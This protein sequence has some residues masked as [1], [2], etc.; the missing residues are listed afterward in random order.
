MNK[1]INT[2][3]TLNDLAFGASPTGLNKFNELI[4]GLEIMEK[5]CDPLITNGRVN[6]YW[7]QSLLE[8]LSDNYLSTGGQGNSS[9][10]MFWGSKRIEIKGCKTKELN[11]HMPIRVGASKFFASNGGISELKRSD[12]KLST[13]KE[14]IFRSSYHDDYYMITETCGIKTVSQIGEIRIIFVSAAKLVENLISNLGP[15]TQ[16]FHHKWTDPNT[17]KPRKKKINWPFLEVNT[18][19]LLEN[20]K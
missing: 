19:T 10:D 12:K 6:H 5:Y 8:A 15:H 11:G 16:N 13:M 7:F 2:T 20:L 9:P 17:G 1:F 3:F 18:S 4:R 14:I